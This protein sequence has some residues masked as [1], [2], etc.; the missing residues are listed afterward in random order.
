MKPEEKLIEKRRACTVEL[1]KAAGQE[2]INRAEDIVGKCDG[3]TDLS[4]ILTFNPAMYPSI[5]VRREHVC[6]E[7]VDVTIEDDDWR[8]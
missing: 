4:V 7:C 1:V 8:W 3:V 6:K 2:V 5:E